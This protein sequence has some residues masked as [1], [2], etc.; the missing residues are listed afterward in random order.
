MRALVFDTETTGVWDFKAPFTAPHQPHLVQLGITLEDLGTGRV[1]ASVDIMVKPEDWVISEEVTKIHGVSHE[2]AATFGTY[3]ANACWMFRDLCCQ[4]DV[5]VAHNI[6]FDIRI[7][8][9]ALWVAG[10]EPISLDRAPKRCTMKSAT[11]ICKIPQKNGRGGVKWPTL[12]EAIRFFYNEELEGA[13][14]AMVD[15]MACRRVHQ[16]LIERGAF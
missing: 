1:E 8:Q 14:N 13:H 4:A 11:A 15:V 5:L 7:M 9:R 3:H 10:I 16:A 6:D 2:R 12:S